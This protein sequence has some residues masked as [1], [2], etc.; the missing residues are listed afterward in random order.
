MEKK[1]RK[2]RVY[3]I[4]HDGDLQ[5]AV[6]EIVKCG[7]EEVK[8]VGSNFDEECALISFVGTDEVCRKIQEESS[9]CL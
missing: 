7:A 6:S 1:L 9:V 5:D 3:E 8:V 2:V 4:E